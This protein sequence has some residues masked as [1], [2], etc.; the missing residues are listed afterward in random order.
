MLLTVSEGGRRV[1]AGAEEG[2]ARGQIREGDGG[3]WDHSGDSGKSAC[4]VLERRFR[5]RQ[6]GGHGHPFDRSGETDICN[7]ALSNV[8]CVLPCDSYRI[9]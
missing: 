3:A 2:E 1:T 6:V 9:S 5:N 7:T 4:S 8:S